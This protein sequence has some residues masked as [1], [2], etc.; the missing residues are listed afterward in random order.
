MTENNEHR[1]MKINCVKTTKRILFGIYIL[2][3]CSFVKE[4]KG[5]KNE[6][7]NRKIEIRTIAEKKSNN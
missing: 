7:N 5:K 6:C 3:H 2:F 1:S 4:K